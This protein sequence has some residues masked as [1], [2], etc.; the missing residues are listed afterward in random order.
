MREVIHILN[1]SDPISLNRVGW[2][3]DHK[4]QNTAG[5]VGTV[6]SE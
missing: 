2:T 3:L 5:N 1:V 6:P 4:Y